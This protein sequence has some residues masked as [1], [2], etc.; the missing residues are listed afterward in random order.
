MEKNTVRAV[1]VRCPRP[2]KL[3]NEY[4]LGRFI[5]YQEHLDQGNHPMVVGHNSGTI[6][7]SRNMRISHTT[8]R[9]RQAKRTWVDYPQL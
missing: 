3:I 5:S 4:E 7:R 6:L 1:A 2:I 9:W 8:L